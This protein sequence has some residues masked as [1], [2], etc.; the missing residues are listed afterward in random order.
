MLRVEI[1][2][3]LAAA[4][5]SKLMVVINRTSTISCRI[6]GHATEPAPSLSRSLDG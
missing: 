3:L 2:P 4:Q 1:G 5:C 6:P